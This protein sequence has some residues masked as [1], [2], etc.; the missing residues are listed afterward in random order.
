MTERIQFKYGITKNFR[1][2]KCVNVPLG[3]Y[4]DMPAAPSDA[5]PYEDSETF[6][7]TPEMLMVLKGT[8]E[9]SM[10]ELPNPIVLNAGDM[11]SPQRFRSPLKIVCATEDSSYICLTPLDNS[12]WQREAA[13]VAAGDDIQIAVP[14][15]ATASYIFVATGS[16]SSPLG[17]HLVGSLVELTDAIQIHGEVDS[18][19]VHLW[20]V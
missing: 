11:S 8:F 12:F 7:G 14:D 19:F 2:A 1:T 9:L 20:K 16:L 13:F 4:L 5:V 3:S 15:G 6:V 10:A 18:H 17:Q